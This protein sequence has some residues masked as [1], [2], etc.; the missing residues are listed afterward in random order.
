MSDYITFLRKIDSNT[1]IPVDNISN[2]LGI[3]SRTLFVLIQTFLR[4]FDN[5][6]NICCLALESARKLSVH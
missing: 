1:L 3:Q 5:N 4:K 2:K 6:K